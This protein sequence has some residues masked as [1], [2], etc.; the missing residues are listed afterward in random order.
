M[1]FFFRDF[2]FYTNYI[3]AKIQANILQI[4]LLFLL[5]RIHLNI[6]KFEKPKKRWHKNEKKKLVGL[7]QTFYFLINTFWLNPQTAL[8]MQFCLPK[9]KKNNIFFCYTIIKP[10]LLLD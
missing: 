7:V 5:P 4:M 10:K 3:E 6:S 8:E 2:P 9:I 1:K